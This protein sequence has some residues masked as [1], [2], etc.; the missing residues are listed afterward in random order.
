MVAPILSID[1][2]PRREGSKK[3]QPGALTRYLQR[4][5]EQLG[6]YNT[7]EGPPPIGYEAGDPQLVACANEERARRSQ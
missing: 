5:G 4:I 2:R 6:I 1:I 7:P 3:Q